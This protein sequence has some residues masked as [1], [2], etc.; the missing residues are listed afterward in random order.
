MKQGIIKKIGI[1]LVVVLI[2]IQFIHPAKN[3]AEV[4]GDNDITK[5]VPVPDEVMTLLK[6]SCFDCHSNHTNYPWYSNIQPVGFWLDDHVNE[7]KRKLNFS[8][9]KTF[10]LK[11]QL[12]KLEEVAEQLEK[13]EMPL[14]SYLIIHHEAELSESQAKLLSDW[15]KKS[16]VDLKAMAADTLAKPLN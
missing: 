6:T 5:V 2:I 1:G 11:R 9:Y 14:S 13:K 10:K 12:H 15:A 4:L 8:E 7:G 3:Q 16:Y